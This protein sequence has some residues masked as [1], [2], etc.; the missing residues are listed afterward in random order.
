[1]DGLTFRVRLDKVGEQD[2][3]WSRIL[4]LLFSVKTCYE[5]SI[6]KII[7]TFSF[8]YYK[9][10]SWFFNF[11]FVLIPRHIYLIEFLK[12]NI[13]ASITNRPI[14]CKILIIIKISQLFTSQVCN[15][16]HLKTFAHWFTRKFYLIR[17]DSIIPTA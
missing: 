4:L 1:M 11:K 15:F 8:P 17:S 5:N 6:A 7:Q 2:F 9:I 16:I 13:L 12:R 14:F 3:P 10:P